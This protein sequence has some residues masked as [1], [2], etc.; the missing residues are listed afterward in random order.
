MLTCKACKKIY[1]TTTRQPQFMTCGHP[2]CQ[3]CFTQYE[4]QALK[5]QD[6][7]YQCPIKV[8]CQQT[9][10]SK[11]VATYILDLLEEA[12]IFNIFCDK[13]PKNTAQYFC[14]QDNLLI[15][16]TCMLTDH[17]NHLKPQ[18]HVHFNSESKEIFTNTIIPFLRN[19]KQRYQSL[20]NETIDVLLY[21]KQ[22]IQELDLTKKQKLPTHQGK[23]PQDVEEQKQQQVIDEKFQVSGNLPKDQGFEIKIDDQIYIQPIQKFRELVDKELNE[24]FVLHT[25]FGNQ[26]DIKYQLLYR[27][28][29]D[30]FTD[31]MYKRKCSYLPNN[32]IF[33]QSSFCIWLLL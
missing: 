30:G 29:E 27:G 12:E 2:I 17:S 8:S 32:I 22:V 4:Q 31:T 14:K 21:D 7:K 15:C 1:N 19:K 5:I 25:A 33:Q 26:F 13:H 23:T 16:E 28:T 11:N 9:Q 18:A 10:I 20:I 3:Q 6:E 24:S